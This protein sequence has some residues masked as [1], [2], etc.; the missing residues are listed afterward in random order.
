MIRWDKGLFF[1]FHRL[2]QGFNLYVR[3]GDDFIRLINIKV[4]ANGDSY[5]I[6]HIPYHLD[7]DIIGVRIF[8]DI[9]G[10]ISIPINVDDIHSK[11]QG[12]YF[13]RDE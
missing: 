11:I 12:L 10:N 4:P 5:W 3:L 2:L 7:G 1:P 6:A 13:H 9:E 8:I